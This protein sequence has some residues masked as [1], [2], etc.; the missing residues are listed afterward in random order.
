MTT[1]A[2]NQ[3]CW[4]RW[5]ILVTDGVEVHGT[6]PVV[7]KTAMVDYWSLLYYI[8]LAAAMIQIMLPSIRCTYLEKSRFSAQLAIEFWVSR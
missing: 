3:R 2:V 6:P 1:D 5:R 4:H 8:Q 7:S